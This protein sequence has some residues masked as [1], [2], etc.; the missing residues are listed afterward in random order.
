MANI[1]FNTYKPL[2]K[3]NLNPLKTDATLEKTINKSINNINTHTNPLNKDFEQLA[4]L[5]ASQIQH[6]PKNKKITTDEARAIIAKLQDDKVFNQV[7][8]NDTNV[9]PEIKQIQES[10]S[11]PTLTAMFSSDPDFLKK[12][13]AIAITNMQKELNN[14][15]SKLSAEEK[16]QLQNTEKLF[17]LAT[18]DFDQ[19]IDSLLNDNTNT[20]PQNLS[21][22]ANFLNY[23][24]N[25][26]RRDKAESIVNQSATAAAA[27]GG[28]IPFPL[29]AVVLTGITKQMVS[30]ICNVYGMNDEVNNWFLSTAST[31]V[32]AIAGPVAV[33]YIPGS[34]TVAAAGVCY[35]HHQLVGRSV[36]GALEHVLK[37]SN[38]SIEKLQKHD[39]DVML[40]GFV[41]GAVGNASGQIIKVPTGNL[42]STSIISEVDALN[43]GWQPPI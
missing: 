22:M 12:L 2:N 16:A 38:G 7:F 37:C 4:F 42:V 43:A 18:M 33:K 11:D 17:Q 34:G 1:T 9:S 24:T 10:F 29:D 41:M 13:N 14:P 23:Y 5:G 21:F 26:S 6:P 35:A 32:G 30:R 36:I 3:L 15:D 31:M 39:L 8:S 27:V 28:T 25:N 20:K 40:E 19:A